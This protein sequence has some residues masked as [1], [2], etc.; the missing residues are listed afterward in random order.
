MSIVAV[1]GAGNLGGS[2]AH[3]LAARERA[4]EIRLIDTADR[5]AAGTALDIKQAGAV[6]RFD[7]SV[8]AHRDLRAAVGA[9]VVVL[10]GPADRPET[11][12][13]DDDGLAVLQQLSSLNRRAV[14]VCAGS[15]HR[16]LVERGVAETSLS[17][18]RLIGAA[19]YALH[20]ALRALV[21]VELQCSV[22]DV[23]LAVLGAPPDRIVVPWSEASVRGV[24]LSRLLSP[25]RLVLLQEKMVR[26]WPPGPYTLA[27]ATARLCDAV[28]QGTGIYGVTCYVVLNGEL[29]VRGKAAATTVTLDASGVTSVAEP[30]LSVRERVEL[31]NALHG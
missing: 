6:E 21:A 12:W 15:G 10:T 2:L 23:S 20:A 25:R 3:V 30:S 18:H 14:T 9:D 31:D 17:R 26:M 8:V 1:V 28:L 11:E 19:P 22:L 29:G 4:R 24:A 16:Q 7:T 13:S 5:V 27:A